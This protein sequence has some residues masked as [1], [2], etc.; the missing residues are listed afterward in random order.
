MS[1][2]AIGRANGIPKYRSTGAAT[3]VT[4]SQPIIR[5]EATATVDDTLMQLRRNNLLAVP[6]YNSETAQYQ[7]IVSVSDLLTYVAFFNFNSD[8]EISPRF[9]NG[10]KPIGDLLGL[11]K[12]SQTTWECAL[13]DTIDDVLEPMSKGVHRLLIRVPINN[14]DNDTDNDVDKERD[15]DKDKKD[16]KKEKEKEKKDKKKDKDKDKDKE[17]QEKE[18][19]I[20]DFGESEVRLVTQSDI[21]RLFLSNFDTS[22]SSSSSSAAAATTTATATTTTTTSSPLSGLNFSISSPVK[23]LPELVTRKIF[24]MKDN[25]VAITGFQ[26]MANEGVSSLAIIDKDGCFVSNLSQSDLRGLTSNLI[27]RV[28]MPV[29]DFLKEAHQGAVP[30]VVGI[31]EETP[32]CDVMTKMLESKVH[33]VWILDSNNKPTGVISMTD[34]IR[35]FYNNEINIPSA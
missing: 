33:R 1:M 14:N 7:G 17:Q 27:Q 16:K 30:P 11:T 34:V 13:S 12:E 4:K 2:M 22:S 19:S 23:E 15:K 28:R 9:E 20:D 25:E 3:L 29:L 5:A 10:T 6:V 26:R 35:L 24:D 21:I 18:T 31:N 32:L 8:G